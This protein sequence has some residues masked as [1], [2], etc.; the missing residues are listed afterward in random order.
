MPQS[1]LTPA[2]PQELNSLLQWIHELLTTNSYLKGQLD[3]TVRQISEPSE[4][5]EPK[6]YK[7]WGRVYEL[8]GLDCDPIRLLSS[9]EISHWQLE[10]FASIQYQPT[11]T[12][13][14]PTLQHPTVQLTWHCLVLQQVDVRTVILRRC[15]LVALWEVNGQFDVPANIIAQHLAPYL[16]VV[17]EKF[18]QK[19][20]EERLAMLVAEVESMF[21]G[22]SR[23]QLIDSDVQEG[24][25]SVLGTLLGSNLCAVP[26]RPWQM[27]RADNT[28]VGSKECRSRVLVKRP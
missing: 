9:C 15:L 3:F 12:V 28:T 17:L 10:N 2:T 22:R 19:T 14:H 8:K 18:Q 24:R 23:Y 16:P 6:P 11:S 13:S 20:L 4:L 27:G 25:I 5:K 21:D 1:L 26:E 7:G